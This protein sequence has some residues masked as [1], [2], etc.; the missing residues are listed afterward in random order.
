MVYIYNGVLFNH[1]EELNNVIC[2]KLDGTGNHHI[3]WNLQRRVSHV[4][5]HLWNQGKINK[6]PKVMKVK[7]ELLGR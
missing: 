3:K 5:S 7:G 6:Q 1:K 2:R 4:F